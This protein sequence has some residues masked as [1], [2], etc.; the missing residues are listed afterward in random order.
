MMEKNAFKYVA[1]LDAENYEEKNSHTS[2][3]HLR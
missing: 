3:I 2:T 1:E